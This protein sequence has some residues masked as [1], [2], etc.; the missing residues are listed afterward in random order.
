MKASLKRHFM[1]PLPNACLG[2]I[3]KSNQA[4]QCC[5]PS[6]FEA[7]DVKINY[8]EPNAYPEILKLRKPCKVATIPMT[9]GFSPFHD[10]VPLSC[11]SQAH[12][13]NR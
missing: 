10:G 3:A 1:Q 12:D 13:E 9:P 5:S 2:F 4:T 6:Y 7:M 8:L 11:K